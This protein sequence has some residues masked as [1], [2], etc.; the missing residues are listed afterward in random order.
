M[1]LVFAM[2][3]SIIVKGISAI[4]EILI[5]LLISNGVGV[6]GY[7]EY[8]FFVNV[9][10]GAYFFLFSGSVKLNTF[11]LSTPSSSL[12]RFKKKYV[13]SY[14]LPFIVIIIISSIIANNKYGILAGAIL[15][16]YYYAYDCS[17]VMFARG[18][19]LP[20]L[21]GEYLF[22]RI[23]LLI[24]TFSVIKLSV[25][26]G[27]TLLALYGLE[28]ITII[29]WLLPQKRKIPNGNN[30]IVVPIKKLF[31]Y[32]ISDVASSLISYSPTIMQFIFGGAFSAGFSGIISTEKKFINFIS[33]P[34]AKVF[35]PEFSRLYKSGEL[36]KLQ[37]SYLMV[38]RI[39]MIFIG[40]I[41]VL[42]ID[43]PR[44]VLKLFSHEL[45]QY[46]V[47]FTCVAICLLLIAGIGPV[48]GLLQMTGN[49][50]I[51]NRNQWI[52][53]GAMAITWATFHNYTF[54][55]IYGLCVQAIIEGTFNYYS[56]C[57]WFGKNILPVK[58]YLILWTPVA[59]LR[60]VVDEMNWDNSLIVLCIGLLLVL[61]WNVFFALK[62]KLV[63]E[64]ISGYI[65]KNN[66]DSRQ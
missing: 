40:T 38:V 25:A 49:E 29:C 2:L 57:R 33:G 9:I 46:A 47:L 1:N 8:S 19:Q 54:F 32:Q 13:L 28:F 63:K 18:K 4:V 44:L 41:G 61:C 53:I 34:T 23:V 26:S 21:L 15:F 24:A 66:D 62:D 60:I 50:R 51:C 52:S 11:Y 65:N 3:I 7:G 16:I 45:E 30:E 55:P 5:Q 14:V 35:L 17:S 6:S 12:S 10:S 64:A 56:V 43:F 48:I 37:A 59:V 22:G 36:E 42:L 58:N 39:Q 27:L 31:H 20:A